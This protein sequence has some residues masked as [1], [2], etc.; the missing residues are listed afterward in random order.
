MSV[1]YV[2]PLVRLVEQFERLPGIG[3]KSTRRLAYYVLGFSKEEMERFA[4]AVREAH[5][6]IHYCR[7]CYNLA[8]Q[9]LCP[10][11]RSTGRD[12][13]IICVVEDSHDTFAPERTS[14]YKGLYHVSHGMIS[15]LNSVGPD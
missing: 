12:R 8:D 6:K 15:P 4:G 3:H 2:A 11:C 5:E 9:E 7:E 14:G 13:S 1:Y 10:I